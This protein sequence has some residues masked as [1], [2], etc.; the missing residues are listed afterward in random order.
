MLALVLAATAAAVVAGA[1]STRFEALP[2]VVDLTFILTAAGTGGVLA[3]L[4]GAL[5][6]FDPDR[7]A[8]LAL[9]GQT[10]GAAA[11]AIVVVGGLVLG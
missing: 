2:D 7:L 9:F 6:R 10:L 4:V 1:V 3:T 5:L 11:G 8:R